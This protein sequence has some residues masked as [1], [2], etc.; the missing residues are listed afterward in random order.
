MSDFGFHFELAGRAGYQGPHDA[1]EEFFTGRDYSDAV[2]RECI[3]NSLDA[4]HND[5]DSV[6]VT[7]QLTHV[8]T[9]E[10]PD[11]EGLRSSLKASVEAAGDLQGSSRLKESLDATHEPRQWVLSISDFGTVG[12]GGTEKIEDQQSPLSILTRGSG[13]SSSESG[14]GG[15][16]GIGSAVGPMASNLSTVFY[17]TRRVDDPDVIL[18]GLAR[19]ASHKDGDDKW[20]V[21]SGY[22]TDRSIAD[23]FSYPRNHPAL[24]SLPPRTE[25]GTDVLI[26]GYSDATNDPL[27]NRIKEAV[28][29][30]F[31]AAIAA[32]RLTV[33][34]ETP[35]SSWTLNAETLRDVLVSSPELR[36]KTLPFFRAMESEPVETTFPDLGLVRL[37]IYEDDTLEH[38]LGTV[39]MRKPLMTI[40]HFRHQ[41]PAPYAAVLVVPDEPGNSRLRDIEPPEHNKWNSHGRRSDAG[42]VNKLKGFVRDELRKRFANDMASATKVKGLE[43]FLPANGTPMSDVRADGRSRPGGDPTEVES[44]SRVG[45]P[46]AEYGVQVSDQGPRRLTVSRPAV[47]GGPDDATKGRDSG[48]DA[49]RKS[50]GGDIEGQGKPG[51]GTGKIRAGDVEFRSFAPAGSK[52]SKLILVP[53]ENTAGSVTLAPLGAGGS[54]ETHDLTIVAARIRDGEQ[55][56]DLKFSGMTIKDLTLIADVPNHIEL[57]FNTGRHYRLGVK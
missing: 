40:D 15:S 12:L 47:S 48:G 55:W 5:A 39:T 3:Q 20:R 52:V 34:G 42:L 24:P 29:A 31:F 4:K 6:H 27:L 18:A 25:P 1:S 33:S 57:E 38:A 37:Y 11:L 26:M 51:D 17:R 16:F 14:R 44:T 2:A 9:T 30:N 13:A 49:E 21:G 8:A 41:I 10:I 43:R 46:S 32:G 23:D 36:D 45:S 50:A 56:Q 54:P 19:L 53:K 7:F 22:F 28:A 35:L